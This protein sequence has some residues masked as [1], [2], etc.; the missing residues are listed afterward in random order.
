MNRFHH[1]KRIEKGNYGRN[2]TRTAFRDKRSG[3]K[4]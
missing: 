1:R 3:E 2:R 4:L